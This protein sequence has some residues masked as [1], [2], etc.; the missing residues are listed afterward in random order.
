MKARPKRVAK[1]RV[2][3][4]E[5]WVDPWPSGSWPARDAESPPELG[6]PVERKRRTKGEGWGYIAA[7]P[8]KGK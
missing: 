1:R 6:R 5:A 3:V 8:G 7:P 2:P 4:E